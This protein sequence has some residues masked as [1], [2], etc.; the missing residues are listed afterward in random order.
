MNNK[1]KKQKLVDFSE[2]IDGGMVEVGKENGL[3]VDVTNIVKLKQGKMPDSVFVLQT[4][5]AR[6]SMVEGYSVHTFKVLFYFISRFYIRII[7][8][9]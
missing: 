3:N 1:E 6:L 2:Y 8:Y 7:I 5:A 9:T 4:F